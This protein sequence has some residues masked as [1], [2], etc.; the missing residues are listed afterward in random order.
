MTQASSEERFRQAALAEGGQPVS[1][2][3]RVE[4]VRQAIEAGRGVYVNLSGVPEE[5]RRAVVAEIEELVNRAS[6]AAPWQGFSHSPDT[7]NT[8]G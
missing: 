6:A 7:S 8:S 3:A 5:R 4:H 1:A 2:G